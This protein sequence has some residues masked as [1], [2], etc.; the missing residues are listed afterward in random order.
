MFLCY[1]GII[2][3]AGIGGGVYEYRKTKCDIPVFRTTA[4]VRLVD[5]RPT[6]TGTLVPDYAAG[7]N[8]STDPVLTQVEVIKSRS[9]AEQV[10]DS[11]GLRLRS[12]TRNFFAGQL[13]N[14]LI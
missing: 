8:G 5:Q 12:Q 7:V 13:G 6:M 4:V 14:V 9:V 1:G 2:V 11:L 10:V 3:L